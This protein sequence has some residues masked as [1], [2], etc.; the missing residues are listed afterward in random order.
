MIKNEGMVISIFPEA[1]LYFQK[2]NVNSN[3]IIKHVSNLNYKLTEG[4]KKKL[5]DCSISEKLNILDDLKFLKEEINKQIE[6]YLYNIFSYKMNYKITNSWA[7]KTNSKGY[8]EKHY[9][10][11]HFLSGVYYPVGNKNFAIKFYKKKFDMWEIETHEFNEFNAKSFFFPIINDNTLIL[12][13]SS[14]EHSIESN[15]DVNPRYSISFN[16]LPKGYVGTN[17]SGTIF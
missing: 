10:S 11:N 2:I 1:V 6:H 12:F 8:G 16:I 7:T 17:D 3:E 15:E 9:H 13:P 5:C 4:S 14:L